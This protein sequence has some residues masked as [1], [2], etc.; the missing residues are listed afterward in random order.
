V[1]AEHDQLV[2]MNEKLVTA[3][4]ILRPMVGAPHDYTIA[5]VWKAQRLAD[6]VLDEAWKL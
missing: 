1:A 2:A 5:D 4:K 6:K 3:L